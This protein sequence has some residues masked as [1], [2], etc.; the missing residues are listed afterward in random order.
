MRGSRRAARVMAAPTAPSAGDPLDLSVLGKAWCD[1]E[2]VRRRERLV[3]RICH[4]TCGLFA[5][6]CCCA[7]RGGR[8]GAPT[9]P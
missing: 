9:L 1:E 6:R 5:S 8:M 4:L 2:E 7:R 3:L